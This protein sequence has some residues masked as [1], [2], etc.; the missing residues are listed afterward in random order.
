MG[1]RHEA[2]RHVWKCTKAP[3]QGGQSVSSFH[4]TP[5]TFFKCWGLRFRALLFG[6]G[7]GA[8]QERADLKQR[9]PTAH[10]HTKEG[11]VGSVS[12]WVLPALS[13]CVMPIRYAILNVVG[14]R[15]LDNLREASNPELE[16]RT[17]YRI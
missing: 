9:T 10:L 17:S 14:S 12:L 8:G 16:G 7:C 1:L 11:L 5:K 3:G 2:L 6:V 4:T 15:V 13:L